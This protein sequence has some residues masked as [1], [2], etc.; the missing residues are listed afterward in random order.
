MPACGTA[1]TRAVTPVVSNDG[2]N[3]VTENSSMKCC[4]PRPK[5]AQSI[6]WKK[7]QKL[8]MRNEKFRQRRQNSVDGGNKMSSNKHRNSSEQHNYKFRK[9]ISI[10][11]SNGLQ[12]EQQK[13]YN[14]WMV[15]SWGGRLLWALDR[16]LR[17]SVWAMKS[18]L[19]ANVARNAAESR[20][21][22]DAVKVVLL[23]AS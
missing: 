14:G 17:V 16:E 4:Q 10:K 22:C 1:I 18:K 2:G 5:S 12:A 6:K 9:L 3:K 21:V 23:T 20:G 11:C 8:E 19:T 13:H 15:A 7:K